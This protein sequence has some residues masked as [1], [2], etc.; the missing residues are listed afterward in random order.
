[1]AI[2]VGGDEQIFNRHNIVLDTMGIG[3]VRDSDKP[4]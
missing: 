4:K 1:M 2:W 3:M